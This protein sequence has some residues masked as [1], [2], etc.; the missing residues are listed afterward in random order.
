MRNCR[1]IIAWLGENYLFVV[2][3][4]KS[5]FLKVSSRGPILYTNIL[6]P[7]F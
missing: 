2:F 1:K 4:V 7:L 3:I 5:S 6:A